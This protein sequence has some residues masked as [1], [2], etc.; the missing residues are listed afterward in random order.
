MPPSTPVRRVSRR[1]IPRSAKRHVLEAHRNGGNALQVALHNGMSRSTAYRIINTE[2]I[3]TRQRG[4][5]RESLV[6]MTPSMKVF[7]EEV[8]EEDPT[9]T[10]EQMKD[11]LQERYGTVVSIS[12]IDRSLQ[13]MVYTTK[14]VRRGNDRMNTEINKEKRR[15]YCLKI[16]AHE[17]EGDMVVYVD[18]T[19]Y[20]LHCKRSFG[21]SV[22]SERSVTTL[23]ASQ[24][25][26]L[27]VQCAVNNRIG[28]VHVRSQFGSIKMDVNAAYLQ[29]V[30]QAAVESEAYASHHAGKK[31][32]LVID[33]APAHSRSEILVPTLPTLAIIRLG[34]YSPMLNPIENCFSVLKAS[35]K[36]FMTEHRREFF[37][38]GTF[39]SYRAQHA[40]VLQQAVNESIGSIAP[41][42]VSQMEGHCLRSRRI[43]LNLGDMEYGT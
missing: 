4:G 37:T 23:P 38:T 5:L 8:V 41:L 34:P 17:R 18:E 33:N 11:K 20:N 28:V 39:S 2:N 32:V 7:L 40:D 21:R 1:S 27:Q 36:R 26:N 30:Y 14:Q 29:E 16:E 43:A 35:I 10:L 15:L 13:E 22:S 19:N 3:E 25:R 9:F 24:G 42:L 12:T 6:K 31:V